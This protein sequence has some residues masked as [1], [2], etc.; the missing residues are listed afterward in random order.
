[1]KCEDFWLFVKIIL[2]LN[3]VYVFLKFFF[4]GGVCFDVMKMDKIL[5]VYFEDFDCQVECGVIRK[6]FNNYLRDI[7]LW[8]FIGNEINFC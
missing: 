8:F 6:I 3:I 7:G 4:Q 2:G 5:V 1:M